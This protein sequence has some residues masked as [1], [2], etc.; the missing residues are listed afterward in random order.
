MAPKPAVIASQSESPL[1]KAGPPAGGSLS[2]PLNFLLAAL[3]APLR[4]AIA[5]AGSASSMPSVTISCRI[6]FAWLEALFRSSKFLAPFNKW[7]VRSILI[8]ISRVSG[9]EGLICGRIK[10]LSGGKPSS[11][12][13][14]YCGVSGGA[15]GL[16]IW[17]LNFLS[18]TASIIL[19][20]LGSSTK[21][22]S[23]SIL[24]DFT[25][26]S[27]ILSGS[28]RLFTNFS[29]TLSPVS[30]PSGTSSPMKYSTRR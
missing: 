28:S 6:S 17:F 11:S 29:R 26:S 30:A 19:L 23:F 1:P 12:S 14:E 27:F 10:S 7:T 18:I 4:S 9:G 16:S 15:A 2:S 8:N 25:I 21:F 3:S 24:P 5:F 20:F 13:M 22:E